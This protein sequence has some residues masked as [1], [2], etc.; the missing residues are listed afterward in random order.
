V[1]S[2]VAASTP[3]HARYERVGRFAVVANGYKPLVGIVVSLLLIG[4]GA[5]LTWAVT[6]DAEGLDVNAVGVILMIIGVLGFA[7][8]LFFWQSWWGVGAWRRSAYVEGAPAPRRRY[9]GGR[10]TVVEEEAPPRATYVEEDVPPPG[11]PP[12]PP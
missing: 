5:I 9:L 8:T 6:A 12:P 4:V 2:T 10:R 1:A 11:G 3:L 7:L